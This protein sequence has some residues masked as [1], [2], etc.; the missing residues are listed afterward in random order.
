MQVYPHATREHE[1]RGAPTASGEEIAGTGKFIGVGRSRADSVRRRVPP[2]GAPP[3]MHT[4]TMTSRIWR[5]KRSNGLSRLCR[6]ATRGVGPLASLAL[7]ALGACASSRVAA[8]QFDLPAANSA[9][10]SPAASPE[11]RTAV[12]ALAGPA[13]DA[14]L[15]RLRDE[16]GLDTLVAGATSDLERVRR[17]SRWVR[18]QWEHNGTNE[19][20]HSD[21]LAILAEARTGK[22][23]RCVEYAAVLAAALSAVGV[24]ARVLGL[25]R[26][27]VETATSG[28]GHV[29]A[30]AYLRDRG[31]WV[32]VDGQWDVIA[33]RGAEP[34]NA[35]QLQRAI[36]E[37]ASDLRVESLSGTGTARYARWIAP[38]L[39]FFVAESRAWTTG[40][41]RGHSARMLIPVGASAPRVFQRHWPQPRYEATSSVAVFYAPPIAP[42]GF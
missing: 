35:V 9:H 15:A 13:P 32:L 33:F 11:L 1:R 14:Y 20:T 22:R 34:L 16:Y 10:G 38:Y 31:R 37:R 42:Q 18:R 21:P 36:A 19:P 4:R 6:A 2:T 29:V 39:F 5:R 24:P 17:M 41:R 8:L 23:F 25:Q 28:A 3:T 30:E 26:S 7:C 27:D 12:P 40:A